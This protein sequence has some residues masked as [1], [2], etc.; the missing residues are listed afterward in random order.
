MISNSFIKS[1]DCCSKIQ[2]YRAYLATVKY[3]FFVLFPE[4]LVLNIGTETQA[5]AGLNKRGI[6][7]RTDQSPLERGSP[8][9]WG[10]ELEGQK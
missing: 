1:H 3:I 4:D 5:S 8:V 6:G 7:Q 9:G 2:E 10:R